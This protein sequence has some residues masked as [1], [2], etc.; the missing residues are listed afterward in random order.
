MAKLTLEFDLIEEKQEYEYA[1]NGV[2]Y[3]L[4]ISEVDNWLRDLIKY[5][6]KE[7]ISIQEVRDK[8]HEYLNSYNIE[9]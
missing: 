7:T 3:S 5:Q 8:L 4:V 6:N 2:K 9:V 1:L